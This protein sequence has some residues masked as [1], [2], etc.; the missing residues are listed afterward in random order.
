MVDLGYGKVVSK[1]EMKRDKILPSNQCCNVYMMPQM[2]FL[3]R[4]FYAMVMDCNLK[5]TTYGANFSMD[6]D[7]NIKK[8]VNEY[9]PLKDFILL[10]QIESTTESVACMYKIMLTIIWV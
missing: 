9:H 2:T 10:S 8:I 5:D 4:N 1:D 6:M 7:D 3:D